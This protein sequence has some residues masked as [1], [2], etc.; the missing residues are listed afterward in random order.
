MTRWHV[1][2]SAI[3]VL[4]IQCAATDKTHGIFEII[5]ECRETS[6]TFS[7]EH[8]GLSVEWVVGNVSLTPPLARIRGY[9][10]YE[11]P[12]RTTLDVPLFSA[13]YVYKDISLKQFYGSFEVAFREHKTGIIL[14]TKHQRCL[15]KTDEF[16][17]CDPKGVVSVV[18]STAM[19]VPPLEPSRTSLLDSKCRP[20]ESDKNRMLFVFTV[21]SCGT[22]ALIQENSKYITYENEIRLFRDFSPGRRPIITRDSDFRLTVRCYYKATTTTTITL[23]TNPRESLLKPGRGAI[24]EMVQDNTKRNTRFRSVGSEYTGIVRARPAGQ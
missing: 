5:S 11:T 10:L 24:T 13:G 20:V 2:Y 23:Q 6:I 8:L 21:N 19:V 1:W 9:F 4:L 16:V 22:K 14:G 12:Q 15:F 17:V 18:A 7:I 3:I